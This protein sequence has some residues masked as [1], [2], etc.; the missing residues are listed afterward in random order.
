[1]VRCPVCQGYL[2]CER[3]FAD[4]AA[5]IKC[6]VCGWSLDDPNFRRQTTSCFPSDM[7]DKKIGW[8]KDNPGFDLYEP[9]SAACQL[10]ISTSFL[11]YSVTHDPAA[12]V[13]LGRGMVACNTQ[14]LQNWWNRKDHHKMRLV[15]ERNR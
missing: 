1:M 3:E 8:R 4:T 5:R 9:S 7:V 11:R 2:V 12:P 14:A 13:I 15:D 10:G 6:T